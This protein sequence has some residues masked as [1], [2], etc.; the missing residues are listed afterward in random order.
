MTDVNI[1]QGNTLKIGDTSPNLRVQL[2]DDSGSPENLSGDTATIVVK[3]SDSDSPVVDGTATVS[4]TNAERGI[5]EYDW[6]DGETDTAGVYDAEITITSGT[7]TATYPNDS[8]FRV[9]IMEDLL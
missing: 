4:S 3:R 9:D 7:E 6:S 5:V 8:F 1:I 2:L